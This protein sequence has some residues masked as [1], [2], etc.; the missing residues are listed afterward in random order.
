MIDAGHSSEPPVQH[1]PGWEFTF[2]LLIAEAS[3]SRMLL[4][5][6]VAGWSLP[7][8]RP[9]EHDLRAVGHIQRAVRR[10]FGL[11]ARVL[12]CL[13]VDRRQEEQQ[14]VEACFALEVLDPA[15]SPPSGTRWVD[16]SGL[17]NLQVVHPDHRAS[18]VGW[19]H[20]QDTDGRAA[21]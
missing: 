20:G 5:R 18:I 11:D 13:S 9:A 21:S 16:A 3:E 10:Q 1:K 15:W 12:R 7:H 2:H 19:L 17:A 4:V 14:R 8:F 6:D